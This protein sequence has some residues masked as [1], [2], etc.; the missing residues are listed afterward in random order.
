[1]VGRVTAAKAGGF[2]V[3]ASTCSVAN[4]LGGYDA[5]SCK[6]DGRDR[7]WRLYLKKFEKL[8]VLLT[9]GA[10]CSSAPTWDR[11]F[12]IYSGMGCT[13]Q[14]CGKK[15]LCGNT[16]AGTWSTSF[17]APEDGWYVVVVDGKTANDAGDFTL[18]L[19]LLCVFGGCEC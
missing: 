15:V 14:G 3:T 7:A 6:D 10:K 8:D 12:K 19:S 18:T 9:Q 13:D 11:V 2:Q 16:G 4:D 5:T 17:V 1:V